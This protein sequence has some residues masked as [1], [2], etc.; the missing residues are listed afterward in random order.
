MCPFYLGSPS[1]HSHEPMTNNQ[2][3]SVAALKCFLV[4]CRKTRFSIA[5]GLDKNRFEHLVNAQ[6]CN[7]LQLD[8]NNQT[9]D[10]VRCD[11]FINEG[12]VGIHIQRSTKSITK[13][14]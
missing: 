8:C 14:T 7:E 3:F 6:Q 12:V 5:V 9:D 10:G 4:Q 13:R 2:Y 11:C 1:I